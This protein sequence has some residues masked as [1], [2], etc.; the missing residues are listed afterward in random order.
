MKSILIAGLISFFVTLIAI[1]KLIRYLK[2]I[3]LEVKDMNKKDFPLIPL[4][5]GI[6]V[7]AGIFMAIMFYIFVQTFIYKN[8]NSLIYILAAM[9]TIVMITFIGFIDDLLIKKNKEA[10]Y[11]LKQWQKPFLTLIA[12]IPLM[13]VNAGSNII[14][15]PFFG[16]I[17]IGLYYSLILIPI[18]VV[19]AAN[20]INLLAGFNGLEAGM[21]LI[22]TGML[23]L[24]AYINNRPIGL[25]LSLIAFC[26]LIPFFIYNKYP[27]KIFPGDSLTYLL[28]ATL[29]CVAILG[30]MERAVL[31]CSIPFFIELILKVRSKFKAETYGYYKDGK[32][33]SQYTKIYSIPHLFTRTGKFSEKQITYFL[34]L[35]ELIFANLI[36]FV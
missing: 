14:K 10:S 19:G 23:S 18:G 3:N 15:I 26:A 17:D 2:R 28:G 24:Y 27:A 30:D 5:G 6:A 32:I 9:T 33:Y 31:I 20:M 21:G 35:I 22:Y 4:S 11:G 16:R 13:A 25:F 29:A 8:K 36:W 1:P 34:I 7:M 12:A